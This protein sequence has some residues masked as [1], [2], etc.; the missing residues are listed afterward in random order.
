MLFFLFLFSSYC[1]SVG[2]H[3][4]SLFSVL[5]LMTI[6]RVFLWS[7][8]IDAP[9]LSSVL[10]SPL[11]PSFLD[12][13]YLSTSSLGCSALWKNMHAFPCSLVHL[14][15]FI[16][17]PLKKGSRISNEGY[18]PG[19]DLRFLQDSFVSSSFLVLLR[20]SFLISSFISICLMVSTSK[21]LKYL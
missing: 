10:A 16:S 17:G 3:V 12:T 6:F 11:P 13:H 20:Y 5:F 14:L 4:F 15:K 9:T 7:R 18:N 8:C 21:M 1:H 2:H 19:N